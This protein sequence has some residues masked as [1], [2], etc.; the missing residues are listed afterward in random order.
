M[1]RTS[2]SHSA[3]ELAFRSDVI[4]APVPEF[5]RISGLGQSTVWAMLADGRLEAIAVGRRRLVL[6]DSYRRYIAQQRSGPPVDCRRNKKT[7]PPLGSRSLNQPLTAPLDLRIED[8]DLS[9]R[10]T[11]ALLNDGIAKVGDLIEQSKQDLMRIPNFG[12]Q[13]L[14]EVE[15][16][17]AKLHLQLRRRGESVAAE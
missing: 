1:D 7:V 15:A 2:T 10:A 17:L 11:N 16:A 6:I 4:S 14:G 12:R 9:T 8:L 3:L 13:G 5:S